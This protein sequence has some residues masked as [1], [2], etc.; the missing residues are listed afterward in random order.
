MSFSRNIVIL[1]ILRAVRWFLVMMPVITIFYREHGLSNED[2]FTIQACF[3]IA[4]VLFEIPTGYFSDVLG[5]KKSLIIGMILW[6]IGI[7]WYALAWGFW[8]F[9]VAELILGLGS[10]FISGTDSAMVYDTLLDEWKATDNKKIQWYLQTISSIAEA[11]ASFLGGFLAVISLVLPFYVHFTLYLL[12]LPLAFFLTEPSQHKHDNKEGIWREIVKIIRYSLHDHKEVKW[13]ILFSWAFWAST[14]VMTWLLQGYFT[15]VGVP[16]V[17]FGVLWSVF[18]ISLVPFSFFAHQIE[19]F[20]GKK[21]SLFFLALLPILG[22]L[23]L[24]YFD[25]LWALIFVFLFYFA[26]GFGSVL[27][28]DYINILIPSHIRA[29]VLSVQALMFRFVFMLV[30]PIVW[31]VSDVYSLQMALTFAGILFCL[32]FVVSLFFLSKNTSLD[33]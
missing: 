27:L 1:F 13:I 10:S 4:V 6:T 9:L 3:A 5:R 8:W 24:A 14:L 26:R 19:T 23:L 15:H 16:L 30:G 7:W 2:I 31:W 12:V 32:L 29:T 18:V 22:Y 21:K 17:Y 11:S 20:L 33:I 28:N 25:T